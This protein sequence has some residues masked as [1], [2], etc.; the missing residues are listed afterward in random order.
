M[1]IP[2][3]GASG[4]SSAIRARPRDGKRGLTASRNLSKLVRSTEDALT[5]AGAWDDDARIVECRSGKRY[6]GEGPD[7]LDV[8]GC[9]I[10]IA[11]VTAVRTRRPLRSPLR[12]RDDRRQE[13][14][15]EGRQDANHRGILVPG[16][17]WIALLCV[18]ADARTALE[19]SAAVGQGSAEKRE[20]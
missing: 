18:V 5:D 20:S 7:A 10:R 14:Y 6:P 3:P 9:V 17:L 4:P 15:S 13:H 16:G 2:L 8:P 11:G 1:V 12:H 19:L